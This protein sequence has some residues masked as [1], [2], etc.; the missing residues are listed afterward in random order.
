MKQAT[1]PFHAE[2][3][4]VV[5]KYWPSLVANELMKLGGVKPK[6]LQPE[7]E[8]KP[9][10]VKIV[11]TKPDLMNRQTYIDALQKAG[12]KV[13]AAKLLGIAETTFR[14]R[15]NKILATANAEAVSAP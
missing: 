5:R 10:P 12:S 4:G 14:D 13:K 6:K 7:P 2:V 3:L 11:E 15:Y 1:D 9:E 8:A